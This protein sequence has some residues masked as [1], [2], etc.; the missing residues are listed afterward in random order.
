MDGNNSGSLASNG[1]SHDDDE[2]LLDNYYVKVND[3]TNPE[4]LDE[5]N[6][7]RAQKASQISILQM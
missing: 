1:V 5:I 2:L 7:I 3:G 6:L 4:Q